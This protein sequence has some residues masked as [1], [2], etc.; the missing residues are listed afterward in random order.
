[1]ALHHSRPVFLPLGRLLFILSVVSAGYGCN[2]GATTPRVADADIDA[3]FAEWNRPD[4]AGCGVGVNL[5]GTMVFERGYGM[6]NLEQKIPIT[7]ATLFDPASIAKPF[8]ALSVMLLAEQGKL[9]LDDEVWKHVPEWVNR[10][11]RVTIRYLLAHTA[12]LRDAFLLI[13]L[14]PPPAPGVDINAH[15]LRTLARQR[16]LSFVPSTEFSYNNGGYNVLGSIVARVSGQSFREF[17]A[18]HLLGPLGMTNSFFRGGQV[19]ISTLHAL[20]YRRD[21]G[22]F[23]LARE[24]GVDTSAIVGNAGLF[25]TV[26]DLLRFAQNLGDARVGGR[27]RLDEMQT[28]PSLGENGTSP[29]G[30][31]LEVGVDRGLKTVGHGG[32]DRGIAAYLIR[33]PAHD[34]NVAV[35]CNLDDLNARVGTLARQLAAL[36]LPGP[37]QPQSH[38]VA[39]VGAGLTLTGAELA[40]YAG[41]YRDAATDTYGRVYVR[42]G[43]LWAS[44]DAGEGPADSVELRPIDRNRFSV[45]GAPVVAEFVAPTGGRPRQIRVTG[46]GPRPFVSEQV[47]EGFAPTPAQ[48]R[49]YAGRYANSDLDVTYTLVARRSGLVIQMPGRGEIALAPVFPDAFYGSLVDLIQFSRGAGPRAVAFT[50]NRTSV[51][52][53]RFERV[54]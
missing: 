1:M 7:P 42:D 50:I 51:R 16:G 26:S 54:R 31:G 2:R 33:Y 4:S 11:D 41:L 49:E 21:G 37:Q 38:D 23:Q 17:A 5:D 20:G 9:S 10:Q 46:A 19:A 14:A 3:L 40:K 8:T 27:D 6:A 44:M 30:L 15:I 24:S 48:L 34:L 28:A 29:W 45:P 32:G 12:G 47:V 53:L 35:L 22:G 25:T 39:P 36:F 13:E 18:A 43:K 52:N